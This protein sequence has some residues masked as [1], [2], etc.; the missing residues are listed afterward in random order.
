MCICCY[1]KNVSCQSLPRA[2]SKKICIYCSLCWE[3]MIIT[4]GNEWPSLK[5]GDV[6]SLVWKTT[7]QRESKVQQDSQTACVH[8]SGTV[9]WQF[10][11]FIDLVVVVLQGVFMVDFY[12][13]NAGWVGAQSFFLVIYAGHLSAVE[14]HRYAALPLAG[15]HLK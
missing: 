11:I 6:T 9:A 12:R 10:E 13:F 1:Q 3:I 14:N 7:R 5:A 8:G 4:L 15:V 2:L